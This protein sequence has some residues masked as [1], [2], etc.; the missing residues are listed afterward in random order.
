M[1]DADAPA[2]Q[3]PWS[4]GLLAGLVFV[5]VATLNAG[6]YRFG[7][8]DQAFYLPAIQRHLVPDSFPRDRL[9]IDDQDRLNVFTRAAAGV[10]RATGLPQPAMWAG[11]YLLTLGLLAGGAV[12]FGRALGLS[13][14]ATV[15]L[16]AAL[17]LKHRVGL[18]GVNTLE[19]YAHPR[20]L[21]FAVGLWGVVWV[22][23]ARPILAIGAVAAAF[24]IHPTTALWFGVWIGV[25]LLIAERR[26]RPL[27]LTAAALVVAAAA[28]AV[29][30]G[31]LNPQWVRMDPEWL[32]VLGTKDY[33][34]ATA[35][36]A[37]MWLVAALYVAAVGGVYAMR[38]AL[39]AVRPR[40]LAIV[41][42]LLALVALFLGSLPLI[43]MRMALVVQ[44]QIS[45]VFWMLDLTA[46][47]YVV[48]ALADSRPNRSSAIGRR[49]WRPLALA[50]LLICAAGARGAYVWHV[51][52]PGR[53]LV[54]YDLPRTDWQDAMDWLQTTSLATHVLADPGHAWREG[55]SVRV[56]AG[57]D[58]Y[59]EEVKDT[60][61]AMYSRRVAARVG[62]RIGA[63][64]DFNALT[65]ASARA[66]ASRFDLDYLV[67]SRALDLPVSHRNPGFTIYRLRP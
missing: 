59:L 65:A 34:F 21:A 51:E 7:V 13:A 31:P 15:A 10:L 43:A 33:L 49:S 66:L 16:L 30:W 27:L 26:A 52:H 5:L 38:R 28:W 32:G 63:L 45:R 56:A 19:G 42:G 14:W 55:V 35:W 41:A 8:G 39:G 48:W 11:I 47:A 36:P 17:T 2:P 54:Q 12:A 9:V 23:R 29:G 44:F 6:G 20:M 64:G 4:W 62:Q 18:T 24:V 3:W 58:V 25:A 37:D 57:R 53:A 60:A 67:T 40:E 61:M 46:T 50:L 1:P 22:L